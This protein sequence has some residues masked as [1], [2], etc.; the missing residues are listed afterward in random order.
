MPESIHING[1]DIVSQVKD[2]VEALR[3]LATTEMKPFNKMDWCAYAGCESKD[4][5]IGESGEFTIVLDGDL[6]NICHQDDGYGG[7][8]F[9]LYQQ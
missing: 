2:P 9:K 1:D 7:T 6:L 8:L 3:M 4:P 5:M